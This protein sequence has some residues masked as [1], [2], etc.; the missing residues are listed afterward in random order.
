[1]VPLLLSIGEFAMV[2]TAEA[3]KYEGEVRIREYLGTEYKY[4]T[5]A[6]PGC[7]ARARSE[8]IKYTHTKVEIQWLC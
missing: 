7:G 3:A 6:I 2:R 4:A 1:M 5:P 8:R